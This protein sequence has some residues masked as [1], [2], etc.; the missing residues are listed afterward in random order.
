VKWTLCLLNQFRDVIEG[1]PRPE[2]SE[3]VY[4][5]LESL[6]RAAAVPVRQPAAQRFVDDIAERPAGAARFRLQLCRHVV[7]Q[8]KSGSHV[9]ML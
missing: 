2:I 6:P 1:K 5:Y 4:R 9:L 7:L 3:I 8:R